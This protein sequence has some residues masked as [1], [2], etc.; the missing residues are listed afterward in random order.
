M[1]VTLEEVARRADVS[2]G[3]VSNVLNEK[4]HVS[5]RLRRK[6]L[7]VMKELNYHPNATARGLATRRTGNIGFIYDKV[8]HGTV[9]TNVPYSK[10]LEGAEDEILAQ[11]RNLIFSSIERDSKGNLLI[12]RIITQSIVD[13]AIFIGYLPE[14]FILALKSWKS[15]KVALVDHYEKDIQSVVT[16]NVTGAYNAVMHL[17]KLGHTKIGFI[18]GISQHSSS[19]ERLEGYKLAIE[20][21]G[22]AYESRLVGGEGM[23]GIEGGYEV[24]LRMLHSVPGLTAI[25]AGNDYMAIGAMKAVKEKGMRIPDD[26]SICGFD[27]IEMASYV[28]PPLTSVRS[29]F[30]EI[31]K[32]VVRKLIEQIENRSR[33]PEKVVVP[34][35]LVVRG[36]TGPVH[37]GGT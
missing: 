21:V 27:D 3:S 33:V 36:S 8:A 16:D 6:V 22:L 14:D 17:L 34:T 10:I 13:G 12:P 4:P 2:R 26:I 29:L 11:N 7:K 37:N 23:W 18:H 19:A 15:L 9:S 1:G 5:N 20:E 25:L 30:V 24:T 31:G 35:E 28:S 32:V